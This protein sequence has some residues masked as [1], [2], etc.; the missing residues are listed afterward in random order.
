MIDSISSEKQTAGSL[1]LAQVEESMRVD[2][3]EVIPIGALSP[4]QNTVQLRG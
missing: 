3:V 1:F 2:G 4:L